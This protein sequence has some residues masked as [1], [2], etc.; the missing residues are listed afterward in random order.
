MSALLG[1]L[2][3][4]SVPAL[5]EST[6]ML[7]QALDLVHKAW[8]PAGD[9]PSDKDRIDLLTKAMSLAQNAPQHRTRGHRVQAINDI[10]A[11][12]S[13]IQRG[14][15]DNKVTGYLHDADSELRDALSIVE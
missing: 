11:A 7:N 15:P 14:D 8:N 6:D 3:I 2:L 13:E 1:V 9:P 12:L 5:A 4:G 10:K